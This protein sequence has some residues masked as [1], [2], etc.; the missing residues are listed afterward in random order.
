[1]EEITNKHTKEIE[2][3]KNQSEKNENN[4]KKEID[5]VNKVIIKQE[6]ELE[7][8]EDEIKSLH[9]TI[10]EIT[11]KLES[12]TH[13]LVTIQN[14]IT[15]VAKNKD[16][17]YKKIIEDLQQQFHQ[18]EEELL[19]QIEEK[20]NENDLLKYN[21][22]Q[23][24]DILDKLQCQYQ[25]NH[26]QDNALIDIAGTDITVEL[27]KIMVSPELRHKIDTQNPPYK[28]KRN[29]NCLNL[30]YSPQKLTNNIR[31]FYN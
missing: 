26:K 29:K 20:N 15:L 6:D 13:E 1:M 3:Y 7:E 8:K 12:L 17:E 18:R 23:L 27:P 19:K 5:R 4:L 21:L 11:Q 28:N 30:R 10:E 14:G 25:E 16:E 31:V 22:S 2:S 24:Q 9:S